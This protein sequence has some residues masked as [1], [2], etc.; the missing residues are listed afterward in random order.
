MTP[1]TPRHPHQQHRVPPFGTLGLWQSL[2]L[3][4]ACAGVG[5]VAL[6]LC[7]RAI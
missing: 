6:W 2:V 1:R 7:V 5:I 4:L 3:L